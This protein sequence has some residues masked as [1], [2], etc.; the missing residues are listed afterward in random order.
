MRRAGLL[1]ARRPWFGP[2]TWRPDFQ[3]MGIEVLGI[4]TLSVS[5]TTAVGPRSAGGKQMMA[6]YTGPRRDCRAG[7]DVSVRKNC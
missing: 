3:S 5:R 2:G 6:R 4:K 7:R 1:E